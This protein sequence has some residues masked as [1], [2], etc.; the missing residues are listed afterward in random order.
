MNITNLFAELQ[1]NPR[2]VATYRKLVDHYKNCN[3]LNEA[4]AFEE[5]I[6]RKFHADSPTSHQ[7]QLPHIGEVP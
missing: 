7:E 3:L 4:E 1:V 5:L 2:S 6:K